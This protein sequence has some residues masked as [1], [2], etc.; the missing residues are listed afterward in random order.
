MK[1][2]KSKSANSSPAKTTAKAA[3]SDKKNE[4]KKEQKL[5]GE[6]PANEDIMEPSTGM[7]RVHV[8]LENLTT[9]RKS[10]K[11]MSEEVTREHHVSQKK[12]RSE[13]D[14]T[15]EDLLALGSDELSSDDGDDEQLKDR[16]L[17]LD[18]S[19]KDLD[20][21]GSELDDASEEIGSEDEENN[22]YSLGGDNHEDLEED[23][24]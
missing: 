12:K 2:T 5:P 21:P 16:T 3:A 7:E 23:R 6:Y 11:E 9:S 22:G 10:E 20:I 15:K 1:T 19:G 4:G 13:S 18:F 8:D 14:V 17:P 24:A